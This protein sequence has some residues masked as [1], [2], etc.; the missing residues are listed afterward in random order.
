MEYDYF[1][2]TSRVILATQI[3]TGL[4]PARGLIPRRCPREPSCDSV[5]AHGRRSK[6]AHDE[7]HDWI[8]IRRGVCAGLT[9]FTCLPV[10]SLPLHAL[11]PGRP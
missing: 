3:W 8:E 10:F 5:T 9:T 4:P 6:Q 11:Q 7:T 2:S 1:Y